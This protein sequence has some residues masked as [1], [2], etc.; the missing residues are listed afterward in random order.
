MTEYSLSD[1][2]ERSKHRLD[3]YAPG[4]R[5][6]D[7]ASQ[8]DPFR[9]YEGCALVELPLAAEA[10]E[11][12]WADIRAARLPAAR[13]LD[14]GSIALLFE[15][16]LAV[17]AWKSYGGTSWALR[18]NPSSG[19]LH[20]TEGYLVAGA[21]PG[22]E[23]GVY[24]YASREHALERRGAWQNAP[25]LGG[26]VVGL[27]SIHWRE[28]WKYGMRAYRYC[29]HDCGHAL[30]ALAY[31]AACLGWRARLLEEPGDAEVSALL[32]LDRDGDY[33][34]AEREVPEA[35]LWIAPADGD[36]P[37]LPGPPERW[38]GRA[39][40]LSQGHVAW[41]DIDAVER[42]ATKPRTAPE[43]PV[44]T[45]AAPAPVRGDA[46]AAAVIRGR[47]S[48]VAFDGATSITAEAFFAMLDA[49][50]PRAAP[51]WS[52][53]PGPALVHPAIF[54]HRVEGLEPGLYLLVREPAALDALR[55]AMRR[56][57]LWRKTGPEGLPL[58]LLLAHDLRGAAQT[59]SCH[60]EIAA[61][62]CFALGML[63]R[64]GA[65]RAEPWRY[66]ALHWE[67]GMLG[68]VLYLEA[69][70]A[71][72]RGTGIGCFFD[73]EMHGLVGLR[74]TE[75][76]T[77]YHFTAGGAVEDTRLTTLPAYMHRR[78]E[79]ARAGTVIPS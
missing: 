4:P 68:Q 35:L 5:G 25:A 66:R 65:A 67:C 62:S 72:I 70:A 7:W 71:G 63:A 6:L 53:W 42:L 11:V 29:Q 40:R 30:A 8:P 43:R 51:P 39:N 15:L 78:H 64:F 33:P 18:C 77:L 20:P 24:H 9:R 56:D 41:P 54:V 47:R 27:A 22:I 17:S 73:D 48:A 58:Y 13:P 3:R 10:L 28:A 75:W 46:S 1:Y 19:N 74:D 23:A 76:Q 57:W 21:I 32:G 50:L 12:R 49:T 44:R 26:I 60:Q 34:D 59:V 14:L 38:A 52:A 55:A 69:E 31:A 36:A 45:P 2:H 37:A 79:L 61:D 16:S